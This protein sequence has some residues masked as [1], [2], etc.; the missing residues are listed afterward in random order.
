MTRH[1]S[2]GKDSV[3][4][5]SIAGRVRFGSLNVSSEMVASAVAEPDPDPDDRAEEADV[6]DR[7]PEAV[8]ATA[9]AELDALRPERERHVPPSRASV[10][11]RAARTSWPSADSRPAPAST[12]RAATRLSVPT[13]EATNAVAGKL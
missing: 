7:A 2:G 6:L 9:L 4:T 8:A 12:T 1:A 5:S 13:N 10:I 11:G 3:T